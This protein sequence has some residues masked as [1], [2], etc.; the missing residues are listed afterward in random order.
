MKKIL[1][2]DDEEDIIALIRIIITSMDI[3][4]VAKNKINNVIPMVNEVKPDLILMD[5]WIPDIGGKEAVKILKNE[6]STADIPILLFSA[7]D[8]LELI[9]E[10]VGAN[11]FIRK[12]FD[13][14]DFKKKIETYLPK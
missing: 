3:E 2:C 8:K 9:C 1:L 5:L 6:K 7:T 11:N 4:F 13:V 10:E 14:K 12:P